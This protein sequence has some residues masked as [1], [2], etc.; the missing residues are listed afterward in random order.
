MKV[1]MVVRELIKLMLMVGVR[2]VKVYVMGGGFQKSKSTIEF[3]VN[4]D[5]KI[6]IG[7]RN[8]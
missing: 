6:K 5:G 4:I 8:K 1:Q 3:K 7:E 2:R